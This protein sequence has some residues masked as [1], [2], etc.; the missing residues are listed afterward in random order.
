MEYHPRLDIKNKRDEIPFDLFTD[1]MKIKYGID[2]LIIRKG[3]E[4]LVL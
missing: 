3:I 1:E 4:I 2:K